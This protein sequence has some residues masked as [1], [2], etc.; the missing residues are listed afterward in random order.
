MK[1][2]SPDEEEKEGG[3]ICETLFFPDE[4]NVQ[5]IIRYINMAEKTLDIAVFTFT[6]NWIRNA[7]LNKFKKDDVKV[8][9][10]SDDE[11]AKH[12]GSDVKWLA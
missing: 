10:V 3:A 2:Y 8:R 1:N 5:E 12:L 6:N 4:H 9:I 7:V 11:C